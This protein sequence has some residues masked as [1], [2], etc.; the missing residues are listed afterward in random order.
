MKIFKRYTKNHHHAEALI[1]KRYIAKEAIEFY[2]NY[3]SEVDYVGISMSH[4][5]G[6]YEGRGNLNLNVKLIRPW[7]S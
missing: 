2:S 7:T 6:R 4:Q 1:I 3:F 5:D